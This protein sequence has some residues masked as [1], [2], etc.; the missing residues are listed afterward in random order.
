MAALRTVYRGCWGTHGSTGV[1]V[2]GV[3]GRA[4]VLRSSMVRV[5]RGR[6]AV[7]G[8]PPDPL[9]NSGGVPGHPLAP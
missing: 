5:S 7:L 6:L 8:C 9:N 3:L 4:A 2:V 1:S